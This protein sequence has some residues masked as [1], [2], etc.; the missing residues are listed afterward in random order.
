ML[1][2]TLLLLALANVHSS[3]SNCGDT[4]QEQLVGQTGNGP[5]QCGTGG[6]II[7]LDENDLPIQ[8]I[9]QNHDGSEVTFGLVQ[10]LF[11]GSV[12][13]LALNYHSGPEEIACEV[14]S[15]VAA[16]WTETYTAACF[17]GKASVK[18]FFHFCDSDGTECDYCEV[19]E[20][21]DDYLALSFELECYQPCDSPPPA[22]TPP[23]PDPD[24]QPCKWTAPESTNC[25]KK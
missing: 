15:G 7:E 3:T 5:Q 9:S 2:L 25:A 22:P 11:T 4:D 12:S 6:N 16:D 21:K 8:I 1:R 20:D 24:P 23:A 14:N 10:N 19:P 17:D 13:K 18:L